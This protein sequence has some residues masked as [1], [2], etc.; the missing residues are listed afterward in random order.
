MPAGTSQP[1]AQRTARR[2]GGWLI[3]AAIIVLLFA[4]FAIDQLRYD[5]RSYSVLTHVIDP[6]AS[7]PLLRL[8]TRTVTTEDFSIPAPS[9]AVRARLYLPA[10]VAHPH[11]MVVVHGIHYL[12]IDEPRLIVFARAIAGSGLAVL[13]PQMDAL[14][15]Y[16]VDA[17]SI[18]KIGESA[19]WLQQRLG[20]GPVTVTGISFAGA[21]S[22]F[23]ACDS[24]YAPHVRAL[25]LIG[26]YD[27]LERV[28]RF[29]A[30][31]E[32]EFPDGRSIP[33][34]ADDYGPSVF[35]YAH[36][37]QFFL[38]ADLPAAHEALREWLSEHPEKAQPWIARLSAPSRA[39]MEALIRDQIENVRP[40]MLAAIRADAPELAALSP[41]GHIAT[42]RVPVFILHGA[43]DNVIP[44]AESLWLEKDVPKQDLRA[45]LISE[46]FSH[47]DPQKHAG[48]FAEIRLVRLLGAVLRAT[49]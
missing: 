45:V 4:V 6:Q 10:G 40:Q 49:D 47:V 34:A 33:Y 7:G 43:A 27:D 37:A 39:T 14:A 22:L 5:L 8:E 11:G 17:S 20:T 28:S 35:V 46:V 48:W 18:P 23:A 29:L 36:L 25:V 3:A 1:R 15:G 9:G 32:E 26:P 42:L 31:N 24:Q 38:A 30:T 41:H 16:H 44:P 2:R 19:R 12:G 21:L 13:T